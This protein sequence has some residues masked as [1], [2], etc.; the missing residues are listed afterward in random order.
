MGSSISKTEA[1]SNT[2]SARTA[3]TQ[4][5]STSSSN[6]NTSNDTKLSGEE[7]EVLQQIQSMEGMPQYK[8]PET[9]QE[10]AYRKVR[11]FL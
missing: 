10:K 5:I 11:V 8:R 6:S 2:A 1:E 9:F 4:V 3:V 7:Y